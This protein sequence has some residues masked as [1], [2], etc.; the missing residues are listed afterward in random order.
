MQKLRHSNREYETRTVTD[1]EEG[2]FA[3]E[4]YR[5]DLGSAQLSARVTDWDAM[6][7]YTV[8]TANGFVPLDVLEKAIAEARSQES[9]LT[10]TSR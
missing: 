6:G 3:V 4:L 7:Q 5:T 8:E 10:Y 9:P 1:L 2:W